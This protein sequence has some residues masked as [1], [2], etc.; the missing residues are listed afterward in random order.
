MLCC[1]EL[2]TATEAVLLASMNPLIAY[3]KPSW[4]D[5]LSFS[6]L[7]L[8]ADTPPLIKGVKIISGAE[9]ASV[10]G[11]SAG[12]SGSGSGSGGGSTLRN[13]FR[14]IVLDL[15]I[16]WHAKPNL[17]LDCGLKGLV[18]H[19]RAENLQLE[20][21]LRLVLTPLVPVYPC[22]GALCFSFTR[23]PNMHF[24]LN[25]ANLNLTSIPGLAGFLENLLKNVLVDLSMSCSHHPLFAHGRPS[26]S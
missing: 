8:G 24:T 13:G 22:F 3:Y 4:L 18:V 17:V 23:K 12:A 14:E 26:N 1:V 6:K 19:A 7:D 25:A 5:F 16:V 2:N 20:C 15:D 9:G 21:T 10:L 11:K